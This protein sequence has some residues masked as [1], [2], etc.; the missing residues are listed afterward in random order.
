MSEP[1]HLKNAPIVEAIIE[2]VVSPPAGFEL[3][4]I[5]ELKQKLGSSYPVVNDIQEN[6]IQFQVGQPVDAQSSKRVHVGYRFNSEDGLHVA[7]L[8]P[9]QFLFSRLKPYDTWEQFSA[10]A[11]KIWR[12]YASIVSP[13]LSVNRV[14]VRF[15]N[16]LNLPLPAN[17]EDYLTVP[18][19][20]P[21]GLPQQASGFFSQIVIEDAQNKISTALIQ[22]TQPLTDPAF[23]TVI[24]DIN[25]FRQGDFGVDEGKIWSIL[26]TL[27]DTKNRVFFSAITEKTSKIY[28]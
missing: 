15:I 8:R 16:Q 20:I 12:L 13:I 2:F 3:E 18:P 17:F 5:L 22:V 11:L 24:I 7:Q 25:S 23:L 14:A 6:T 1:K 26:Q 4:K 19:R 10:E 21:A 27:R 9:N 28:E